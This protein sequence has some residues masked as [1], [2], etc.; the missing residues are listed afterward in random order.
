MHMD[1]LNDA[2]LK[3]KIWSDKAFKDNFR[4]RNLKDRLSQAMADKMKNQFQWLGLGHA[5]SQDASM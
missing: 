4:Q 5:L 1:N 2:S 3:L